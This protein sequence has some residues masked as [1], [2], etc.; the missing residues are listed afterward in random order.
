MDNTTLSKNCRKYLSNKEKNS[1]II[2]ITQKLPKSFIV[3]MENGEEKI[4]ISQ[5]LT[6][7]LVKRLKNIK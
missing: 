6:S 5:L 1:K 3:C 4:Y 2:Y 7:T